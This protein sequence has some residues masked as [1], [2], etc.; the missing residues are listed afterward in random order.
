MVFRVQSETPEKGI[1]TE[2]E[3]IDIGKERELT[4]INRALDAPNVWNLRGRIFARYYPL[5]DLTGMV[6][7][8]GFIRNRV[9]GLCGCVACF[10]GRNGSVLGGLCFFR[11]RISGEDVS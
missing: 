9:F 11:W 1:L 4:Y 2:T 8:E 3:I 5:L 6:L 10:T 7:W